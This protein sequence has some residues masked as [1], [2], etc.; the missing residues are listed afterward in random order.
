MD[1]PNKKSEK[2]ECTLCSIVCSKQSD[3]NR[4]I[5]TNK[6]IKCENIEKCTNQE[7]QLKCAKCN[8]TYSSRY[9][10]DKHLKT[11][12]HNN[13]QTTHTCLVCN[14]DFQSYNSLW[15]HRKKCT[16]NH[17]VNV[18]NKNDNDIIQMLLS[19]N[20]ELKTFLMEQSKETNGIVN[21]VL[22]IAKSTNTNNCNNNTTN[23]NQK[24]NINVF[25]NEQCKDAINFA[26]FVKNIE[27]SREDI[28]NTGQLGFVNGISK[29]I[30]DNLKQLGVN[31]RPIHCTD[32]KRE[33]MYIKDEDKWNKEED[34][35]KLR[36]A[37]Q[38]VSRK[39]MKTLIDWK[40]VNP[41]YE[42]GDSEFSQ[43]CLSMQRHSVA[44]DDREVYYPKVAKLVAKEV[45]VDKS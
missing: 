27:V 45:I 28:Q 30:M 25:L 22:E 41:D 29:I 18:N 24:F 33:T 7:A 37:I 21:K 34:D 3:W 11:K 12:Y 2:Y 36:N 17:T 6:H 40:Q 1:T 9:E 38:T 14:K 15:Y 10:L 4:H 44:G 35:T 43:E 39:S 20:K 23:N 19:E 8:R 32:L 5:S 31:E 16:V 42:D 13:G 26:D